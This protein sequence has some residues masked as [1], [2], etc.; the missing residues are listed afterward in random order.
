[1]AIFLALMVTVPTASAQSDLASGTAADVECNGE[2]TD[3]V[4][5]IDDPSSSHQCWFVLGMKIFCLQ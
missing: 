1:M 3:K 5:C 2:T 4:F